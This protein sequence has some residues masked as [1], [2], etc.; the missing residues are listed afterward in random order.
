V[1][2][3]YVV[4][5]DIRHNHRTLLRNTQFIQSRI[6]NL[7]R[8]ASSDGIRQAYKYNIGYPEFSADPETR[9]TEFRDFKDSIEDLFSR[10]FEMC[11]DK[12]HIKINQIV[13]AP[14]PPKEKMRPIKHQRRAAKAEV[15][16]KRLENKKT[17]EIEAQE[18]KEH[19]RKELEEEARLNKNLKLELSE[20]AADA[21]PKKMS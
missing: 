10:A 19:E 21:K 2:L 3:I 18:R 9:R 6:D 8:I 4:L 15:Q 17:K 7:S 20:D 12:E 13:T 1:T 5:Y 11:Q 16:E 14:A